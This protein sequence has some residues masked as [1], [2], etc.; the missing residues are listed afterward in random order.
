M[1]HTYESGE[2]LV[3]WMTYYGLSFPNPAQIDPITLIASAYVLAAQRGQ[4]S[5]TDLALHLVYDLA[6]AGARFDAD[7]WVDLIEM[8][9]MKL[10]Q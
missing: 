10:R 2:R 7:D 1:A 6:R 3:A 5:P 4:R 9:S 8:I